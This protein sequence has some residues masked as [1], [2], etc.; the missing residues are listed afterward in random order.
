MCYYAVYRSF[1]PPRSI[2]DM[3]HIFT[4]DCLKRLT[5]YFTVAVGAYKRRV[6]SQIFYSAVYKAYFAILSVPVTDDFIRF[7]SD[8]TPIMGFTSDHSCFQVHL[9]L[10]GHEPH[11][12]TRPHRTA[13]LRSNRIINQ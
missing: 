3:E 9:Y 5:P 11:Y 6:D 4:T 10:P 12:L 7:P 1:D 2:D 8:I 13:L